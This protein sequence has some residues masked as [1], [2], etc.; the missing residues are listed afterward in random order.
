MSLIY[1]RDIDFTEPLEYVGVHFSSDVAEAH[2][3]GLYRCQCCSLA[4]ISL[5]VGFYYT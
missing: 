4:V 2:R 1:I 3:R 5:V